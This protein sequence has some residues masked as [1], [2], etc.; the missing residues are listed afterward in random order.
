MKLRALILLVTAIGTLLISSCKKTKADKT[1]P[2][3]KQIQTILPQNF[4]DSLKAHGLSLNDGK[5]PPVITGAYSF[6]PINDYD[7]SKVFSV[8]SPASNAKIK[9]ANQVGTDAQVYIKGWVSGVD[10]SSAQII[11][12]TANDFTVYAQAHGGSPVYT[13]DYVITGTYAT[14]GLQNLKFAFVMINNGGNTAAATTGTIRIFHDK[15]NTASL[16]TTFRFVPAEDADLKA[17][18]GSN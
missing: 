15:D 3:A 17:A 5:T 18:G 16:T 12:G 13:Y 14:T 1:D 10:T 7:N 9:I 4:I 2:V 11:A 6:D 8:G